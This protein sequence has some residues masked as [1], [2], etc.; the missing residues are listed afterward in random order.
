MIALA[1][2][3]TK[4]IFNHSTI[5]ITRNVFALIATSHLAKERQETQGQPV[6][7]Q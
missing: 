3:R 1:F 5:H 4:A 6:V 2:A 7:K